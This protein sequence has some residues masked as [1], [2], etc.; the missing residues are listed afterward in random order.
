MAIVAIL[1]CVGILE[2]PKRWNVNSMPKKSTKINAIFAVSSIV[3]NPLT[4]N[5]SGINDNINNFVIFGF[6]FLFS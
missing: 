6:F 1:K 3:A 2:D 5:A 4:A